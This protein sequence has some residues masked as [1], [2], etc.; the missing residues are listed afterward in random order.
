[1][2]KKVIVIA[3]II[4]ALTVILALVFRSEI[5]RLQYQTSL[6]T[7]APQHENFDR[8]DEFYPVN[9][10]AASTTPF[11]FPSGPPLTL[12]ET[13]SHDDNRLDVAEFLTTTDT[14]AL[15]IL[16]DGK[17]VYENYFL[18]GG[19][20]VAWLTHSIS[21]SLVATAVAFTLQDGLLASL[22]DKASAYLPTLAGSGY[23]EVT[24]KQLLQMSSGVR[25]NEDYADRESDLNQFGVTILTGA[26]YDEFVTTVQGEREPG[27]YH[28]YT[29]MDSQVLSM[30]VRAITRQTLAAYLHGKLWQPLGMQDEAYWSTDRHHAELGLGGLSASARDLA[31]VGELYRRRGRWG[32]EQILNPQFVE[33]A[34]TVTNPLLIRG[35]H[36][37]SAHRM[38]YGYHWWLPD[39]DAQDYA[40]IGIYNQFIYVNP[41]Y[42]AVIVK[43]SAYR[44]YA[45]LESDMPYPEAPTF[46]LF[47]HITVNLP[48][49]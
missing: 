29:G 11:S 8:Q 4:I 5:G 16:Q 38:G 25:W 39:G 14:A 40:A 36:P 15:L 45:N 34:T 49:Y 12:P 44:D 43:L 32:E 19:P 31:K 20:S 13:F 26:S 3:L 22:E 6:F 33:A 42:R 7:G 17:L 37:Q 2:G 41:Q 28:R 30:L 1:M 21:K 47:R 24:V 18:N 35:D 46:S 9:R 10:M 27:S 23:A 48:A